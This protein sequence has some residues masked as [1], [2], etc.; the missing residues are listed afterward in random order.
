MGVNKTTNYYIGLD[1]GMD[2]A[3]YAVTTPQYDLLQHRGEPM[4]GVSVFGQAETAAE[5]RMFRSNRRNLY[6]KNGGD[7]FCRAFL[8]KKSPR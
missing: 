5:R 3:G 6:R 7:I 8:Q 2:S 1:I 4:W